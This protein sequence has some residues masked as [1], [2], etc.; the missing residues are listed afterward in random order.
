MQII[1]NK[2]LVFNTRNPDKYTIIPNH[3]VVGE[4]DGVAQVAVK[5]GLDEVRVLRN[6]GVK[7]VPSPIRAR[8]NW[9]GMYKPF[10]HQ[11]DTSEF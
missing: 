7:N 3:A 11:V 9:P 4:Q 1:E 8:Y 5:W 10:E 6:L 2:A